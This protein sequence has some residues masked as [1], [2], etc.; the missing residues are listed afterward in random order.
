MQG[1]NKLKHGEQKWVGEVG[2]KQRIQLNG[3][4]NGTNESKNARAL[5][6]FVHDIW[7]AYK[8]DLK[9]LLQTGDRIEHQW[10]PD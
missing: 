2:R 5:G 9:L 4:K 6:V 10:K 3:D 8:R 1:R 7:Y